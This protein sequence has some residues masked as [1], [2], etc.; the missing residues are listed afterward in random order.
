MDFKDFF[1]LAMPKISFSYPGGKSR[2]TSWLFSYFPTKGR[3]FCEPF[4]GL[5]N[6]FFAAIQKLDFQ[7]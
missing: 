6:V 4:C 2:M 1:E 7:E 3:I 5:G